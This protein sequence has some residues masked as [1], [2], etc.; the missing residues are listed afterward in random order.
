NIAEKI[1]RSK[2]T[3]PHAL[4][5]EEC[6]V[7][8][9]VVLRKRLNAS[10]A[11]SGDTLKVSFLPFICKALVPVL[12]KYPML[13]ANFDDAAQELVQRGAYHF[14]IAAATDEGLTVP[15][16]KAVDRLTN[17]TRCAEIA[18]AGARA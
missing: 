14:G 15:V 6:D 4:F 17:R 7:T 12:R 5:V 11:E 16:V 18:R 2:L 8:E 10:L 13:N 1:E 3:A 9:L